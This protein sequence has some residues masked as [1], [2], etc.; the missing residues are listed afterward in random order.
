MGCNKVVISGQILCFRFS[1]ISFAYLFLG[2][3]STFLKSA[4]IKDSLIDKRQ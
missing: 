2:K 3:Y 4:W 1:D